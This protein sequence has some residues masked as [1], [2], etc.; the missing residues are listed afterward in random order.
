M[1]RDKWEFPS[2]AA[3]LAEAAD[4]K[5]Q[6]HKK[7]EDW[8]LTKKAETMANIKEQ[9]LEVDESLLEDESAKHSSYGRRPTIEVRADL[10][11]DLSETLTKIREHHGKALEYAGWHEVFASQGERALSLHHD[12][13]LYF[14]SQG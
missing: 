14:F 13:W 7:R 1:M 10:I 4:I 9:G 6:H 8:W 12:D 11:R 5:V 2:T 3:K